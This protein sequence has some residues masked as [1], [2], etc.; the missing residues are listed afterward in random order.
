MSDRAISLQFPHPSDPGLMHRVLNCV[1]D[2]DRMARSNG[3]GG[4]DE[5]SLYRSGQFRLL[6][7]SK[8]QLGRAQ[9]LVHKVLTKHMLLNEAV[10]SRAV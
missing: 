3:V 7:S 1:E 8:R 6:V 9:L 4:V 10:I 5:I 2:L